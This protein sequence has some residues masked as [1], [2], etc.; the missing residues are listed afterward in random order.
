VKSYAEELEDQ[1]A[2]GREANDPWVEAEILRQPL[3]RKERKTWKGEPVTLIR[4]RRGML[5]G[6]NNEELIPLPGPA[7]ISTFTG[8]GGFD[9]G[10]E[11]AGFATVIQHEWE[12]ECCQTLMANRPRYFRHAA[13]IQGD[14]R[15]TP[16]SLLLAEGGLRVGEAHMVCGGPPCQGYSYSGK[17]DPNDIRNN[18]IFDFL[19]VVREAQPYFFLFENVPGFVS[20]RRGAFMRAFLAAAYDSY[21]EIV[22]GLVDAVEYGVPQYRCR[23]IAAGTR[24]DLWEI[25]GKLAGLPRPETFHDRELKRLKLID[26]LPLWTPVV[27]SLTRAPGIRHF[28]DRPVLVPPKPIHGEH[29]EG[30]GGRTK[31]F[32]EFYDRLAQ[33]EPDRLVTDPLAG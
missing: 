24:R 26:R 12:S 20:M 14:I 21:Y 11:A 33:E 4:R 1:F 8:A 16:T 15:Q 28:P 23:F 32:I 10:L 22:Y 9:L 6:P 3:S 2:P 27:E 17:R 31:K 30:K 29:G 13:L 5:I 7:V 19:R 18:L 25:E